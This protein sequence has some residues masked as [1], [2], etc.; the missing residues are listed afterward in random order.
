M[1]SATTRTSATGGTGSGGANSATYL[2][3]LYTESSESYD[4]DYYSRL[5]TDPGGENLIVIFKSCYP[6]SYLLGSPTDPAAAGVNP[7]RGQPSWA[8]DHTVAN[9]KGIYNDILAY[10]A[11]RPDKLFVV[12]T[13]PPQAASNT[14]AVYA[15]NARALNNWLV[16]DWLADYS[17][18]NVAVFDFF[19]LLTSNGGDS[20]T[21][22]V[23]QETGNHHRWWN[24][25]VQHLQTVSN[26]T[27]AYPSDEW[28]DHPNQIGNQKA[29]IEFAPLLNAWRHCWQGSGDCP[30]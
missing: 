17:Q 15:A 10:F 9:A 21:N 7:L 20:L 25:A 28:D 27:A 18:R 1:A 30:E 11:T 3:A 29:T 4:W 5:A 26:D 13:A 8:A 14:E 2:S 19:N 12:I 23:G 6:N 22:D 24:G 16:N